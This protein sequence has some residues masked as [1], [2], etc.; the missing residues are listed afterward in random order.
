MN[1]E[2]IGIIRYSKRLY[3][4]LKTLTEPLSPTEISKLTNKQLT[5]VSNGL[6][7]L[8]EMGLVENMTPRTRKG[9]IYQITRKGKEILKHV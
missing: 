3:A 2:I 4:I 6:K 5:N 7:R 8:E 9:K 1:W